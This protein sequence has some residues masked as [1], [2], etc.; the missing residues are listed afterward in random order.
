MH[1]DAEKRAEKDLEALGDT[2]VHKLGKFHGLSPGELS[3]AIN[4]QKQIIECRKILKWTY[5]HAY[6]EYAN[7]KDSDDKDWKKINPFGG[8]T[9][10]VEE[11][12]QFYEYIQGEAESR[13]EMLTSKMEKD[14]QDFASYDSKDYPRGVMYKS[15]KQDP[16]VET[17]SEPPKTENDISITI[18]GEGLTFSELM[19]R[20]IELTSLMKKSFQ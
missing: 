7:T 18:K 11:Q 15:A 2:I 14:L 16:D 5:A 20:V 17:P 3:F 9:K 1:Q 12:K 4:A 8:T 19:R 6:F 13:L 10:L